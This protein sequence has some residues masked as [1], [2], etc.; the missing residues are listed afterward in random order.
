MLICSKRFKTIAAS[1]TTGGLTTQELLT[2][3]IILFIHELLE[4]LAN[5]IEVFVTAGFGQS[6]VS[7]H[8]KN[9]ISEYFFVSVVC[10]VSL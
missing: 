1:L 4:E 7:K 8:F 6:S 5:V 2:F 3:L 9:S 10:L